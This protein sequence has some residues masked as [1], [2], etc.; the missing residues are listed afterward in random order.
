MFSLLSRTTARWNSDYG[1]RRGLFKT[2]VPSQMEYAL[3]LQPL[4]PATFL[5]ANTLLR[6]A[7]SW[8]LRRTVTPRDLLR[9]LLLAG[10]VP[11]RQRA[12]LLGVRHLAKFQAQASRPEATVRDSRNWGTLRSAPALLPLA[13]MLHDP[14]ETAPGLSKS[15]QAIQDS[16]ALEANSGHLRKIPPHEKGPPV[17]RGPFSTSAKRTADLSYLKRLPTDMGTRPL[18]PALK[19]Q[20]EHTSPQHTV[21][22]NLLD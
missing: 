19:T 15:L 22:Q 4:S 12:H 21:L 10:L 11:V 13:R 7:V 20:L 2:F 9:G 14:P 3:Y 16:I 8:I 17:L 18:L 6:A 5:R 1:T